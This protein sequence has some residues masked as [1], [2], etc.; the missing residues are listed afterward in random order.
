MWRNAAETIVAIYAKRMQLEEYFRDAKSPRFG[1]SLDHARSSSTR[2]FDVLLL[3]LLLAALAFAAVVL[4]GAAAEL[5]DSSAAF[6]QARKR[7]VRSP[8]HVGESHCA[9]PRARAHSARQRLET[10]Q[11]ASTNKR[12][13][14]PEV[15]TPAIRE[16]KR[17]AAS[18]AR[19]LLRRLR[20]EW[21]PLRLAA[22][23]FVGIS[24]PFGAWAVF[25][26]QRET[27]VT[28][29]LHKRMETKAT[30]L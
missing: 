29:S 25:R 22:L 24:Q 8:S 13:A 17:F 15:Q 12:G 23:R 26:L 16:P 21:S 7:P 1:W 18:R 9:K 5:T 27:S 4:I 20:L 6:A 30:S 28:S 10:S 11:A 19:S 2:R 3:L 14:I